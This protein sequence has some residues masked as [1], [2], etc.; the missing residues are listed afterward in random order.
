MYILQC[1][2]CVQTKGYTV[3]NLSVQTKDYTVY[4]LQC[5][6]ERLHSVQILVYKRKV[7]QCTN[8]S[9]QTKCLQFKCTNERLHSVQIKVNKQITVYKGN[10][11]Y[12]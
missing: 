9:V 6:N 12:K 8:Y 5:T 3:Y 7:K 11:V 2:I 4:K 1:V 10:T